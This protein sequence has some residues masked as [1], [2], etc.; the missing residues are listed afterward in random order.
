MTS[1]SRTSP[2]DESNSTNSGLL[3]KKNKH[4]DGL[5][6]RELGEWWTYLAVKNC[7][8]LIIAYCGGKRTEET[9]TH[10]LDRVFERLPLPKPSDPVVVATDGNPQDREA[11]AKLY[12]ESCI[13]YGQVFKQ[14]E[15]NCLVAV[16]RGVI[17]GNPAYEAIS[18]SIVEGYNN[19][20]RQR[21]S[22]FG[23]KTASFTKKIVAYVGAMNMFQFASNFIDAKKGTTAAM[24][25]GITDH[26]WTQYFA[27]TGQPID[28]PSQP[29]GCSNSRCSIHRPSRSS[30]QRESSWAKIALWP[31]A[32]SGARV[33]PIPL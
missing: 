30:R 29:N 24:R 4:C 1:F 32:K 6:D 33:L 13:D 22:R 20:I 27:K 15:R 23:R 18:T 26:V 16:I 31:H 5:K 2:S 28:L 7:S 14:R 17:W 8:G 25:E 12:C 9:C 10:F 11:L 3:S 19:K 21:N